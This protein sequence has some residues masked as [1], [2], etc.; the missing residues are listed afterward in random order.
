MKID[1]SLVENTENYQLSEEEYIR[2]L[3]YSTKYLNLVSLFY[4]NYTSILESL[5]Y[6]HYK[7]NICTY[8]ITETLWFNTL[9]FIEKI[10][11]F[12]KY[13]SLYPNTQV[14][15]KEIILNEFNNSLTDF[16]RTVKIVCSNIEDDDFSKKIK[17]SFIDYRTIKDR[18]YPI[19]KKYILHFKFPKQGEDKKL[20]EISICKYVEI[21]LREKLLDKLIEVYKNVFF[22]KIF[23]NY[24]NPESNGDFYEHTKYIYEIVKSMNELI[25]LILSSI[26]IA[27][28]NEEKFIRNNTFRIFL[29]IT[30]LG[31]EDSNFEILSSIISEVIQT[32]E[33]V[34]GVKIEKIEIKPVFK[35]TLKFIDELKIIIKDKLEK[36][37][38]TCKN[39]LT[40]KILV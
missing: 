40:V 15:Y 4:N 21:L 6:S 10:V 37:K 13:N 7:F 30:Y 26:D 22:N 11:F 31:L 39:N 5:I 27:V 14:E 29:P 9:S 3:K 34:K 32:I 36:F 1:N 35:T 19:T 17:H 24:K 25:T 23:K 18:V 20:E 12:N 8:Y 2:L 38:E 16:L 28:H 33:K